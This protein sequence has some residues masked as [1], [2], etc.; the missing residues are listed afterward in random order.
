MLFDLAKRQL[1]PVTSI[2]P[3]FSPDGK[4]V[5]MVAWATVDFAA[6]GELWVIDVASKKATRVSDEGQA[7]V[8][9]FAWAPDS[10]ELYFGVARTRNGLA[11]DVNQADVFVANASG[12]GDPRRI[13]TTAYYAA[14]SY[15][16]D[17]RFDPPGRLSDLA[18]SPDGATL[19][20]TG[21]DFR[22]RNGAVPDLWLADSDGT[23]VRQIAN[24]DT[25]Q[26]AHLHPQWS[27]N[28]RFLAVALS[29]N[30][31]DD[32]LTG[33]GVYDVSTASWARISRAGRG[34]GVPA[35][36]PDGKKVAFAA[37]RTAATSAS[38]NDIFVL[39]VASGSRT[40][41]IAG[42]GQ[43]PR[44]D[45]VVWVPCLRAPPTCGGKPATV[46]GTNRNDTING[47]N[48]NDVIMTFS[49][50]DTVDGR[51]G[52]DR[53]CGASGNDV[54]RGGPGN[55]LVFGDSGADRLDGGPGNDTL[56]GGTQTDV[57]VSG[58]GSDRFRRCP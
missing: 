9:T 25:G 30:P 21:F 19:A 34:V 15:P 39:D 52:N 11:W 22:G 12:A 54:L 45:V 44:T 8:N 42:S 57:C 28:G 51:G 58:G 7:V 32:G 16:L 47:T 40:R 3:Q 24:N 10:S 48:G 38:E 53:I 29:G 4:Q 31:D 36:S 20:F 23:N 17:I 35:W 50:N 37:D 6:V 14:G 5:A 18:V 1:M 41:V 49:G 33:A 27:P 43:G 13:I 56:D 46:L 55:D 2:R 26:T